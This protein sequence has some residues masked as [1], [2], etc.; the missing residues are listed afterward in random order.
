[1]LYQHNGKNITIPDNEIQKFVDSLQINK[2]EAIQLWLE[3]N[4]IIEDEVEKELTAKASKQKR[5][6]ERKSATNAKK[7]RK[8]RKKDPI[9]QEIIAT[10]AR[11]LDRFA[12]DD[13]EI[14][15]ISVRNDEKY[16]DFVVNGDEYTINLVKHRPKK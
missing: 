10:I 1:M 14:S 5:R 8:P 3:D 6:Y 9:K 13:A 11:N 12:L 7:V 4:D 2:I 16:I 15:D